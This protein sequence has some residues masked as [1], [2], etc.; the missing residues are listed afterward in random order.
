MPKTTSQTGPHQADVHTP[1]PEEDLGNNHVQPNL[2]QI[3][4]TLHH[5]IIG[6]H[7]Y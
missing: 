6:P 3:D 2:Y 7:S 5:I 1:R 4:Y